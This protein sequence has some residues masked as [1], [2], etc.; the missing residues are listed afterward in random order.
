MSKGQVMATYV[1]EIIE[2][3]GYR[4]TYRV[5]GTTLEKG[6]RSALTEA[7]GFGFTDAKAVSAVEVVKVDGVYRSVLDV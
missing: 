3:T 4:G 5:E 6:V 1:V 2:Y 7:K